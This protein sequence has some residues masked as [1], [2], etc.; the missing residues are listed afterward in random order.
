MRVRGRQPRVA[1]ELVRA[2]SSWFQLTN[3]AERVHRIR[4]RRM[5]FSIFS[6]TRT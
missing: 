4:R 5:N 1:R 3:L 6:W 2:F